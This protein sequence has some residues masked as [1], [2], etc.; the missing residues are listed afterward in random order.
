MKFELNT[1]VALLLSSTLTIAHP[2]PVVDGEVQLLSREHAEVLDTRN[3]VCCTK[4]AL[5]INLDNQRSQSTRHKYF[6]PGTPTN[7]NTG[8]IRRHEQILEAQR[9]WRWWW[10]GRLE[11]RIEQFGQ[12]RVSDKSLLYA[13]LLYMRVVLNVES[14]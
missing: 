14:V 5:G 8:S 3:A 10:K 1:L 9:R 2:Q 12:G 11:F 7:N 6:L 4:R 13:L